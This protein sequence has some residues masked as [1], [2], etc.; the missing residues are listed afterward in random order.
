MPSG[1]SWTSGS[2]YPPVFTYAAPTVTKVSPS[3]SGTAGATVSI[4]GTDFYSSGTTVAFQPVGGGTSVSGTGVTV[5]S[6]TQLSVTAPSLTKNSEYYVVVTTPAGSSSTSS[7]EE[8]EW[9]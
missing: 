8:Y 6:S 4:T 3:Q 2:P 7:S 9:T 5:T 1:S